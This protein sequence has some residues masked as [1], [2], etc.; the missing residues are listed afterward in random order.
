MKRLGGRDLRRWAAVLLAIGL[1][2][3][4][5]RLAENFALSADE[6]S[7]AVHLLDRDFEGLT[8]PL[9]YGQVAPVGFL[10]T[11]LAVSRTLGLSEAALRLPAWIA[12]LAAFGLFWS[13]AWRLLDRRRAALAVGFFAA[14]YYVV[15]YGAEVKPYAGDVLLSLG[16]VWLAWRIL[17]DGQAVGPKIGLTLLAAAGVW[18]SYP[19]VFVA[20]GAGAVLAWR[21]LRAPS[22]RA[23]LFVVVYGLALT[24]SFLSVFVLIYRPQARDLP[25]WFAGYWGDAF[26]PVAQPLRL[27]W[28][29]ID[30][31]AGVMLAYPAGAAHFGSVLTLVCVVAGVVWMARARRD[32]L[33]LLLSPLPFAFAAAALHLYPY[34]DAIR[35]SLY[36][37]PAFCLLA[38]AG[39]VTI[40]GAALPAR[41][42]AYGLHAAVAGL[43][44][45]AAGGMAVDVLRPYKE[46]GDHENR[47]VLRLLCSR[48]E[49]GDE[50]VVL[51]GAS[52]ARFRFY[53][54]RFS[55]V[56]VR[57]EGAGLAPREP[58]RAS[59]IAYTYQGTT[60]PKEPLRTSLSVLAQRQGP[61][62][63]LGFPLED[64]VIHVY[65]FGGRFLNAE[66]TRIRASADGISP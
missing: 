63:H 65:E 30:I 38:G 40:L 10:W 61:W 44:A 3:R 12:S 23:L 66:G 17:E 21:A 42:A 19:A 41:R 26:P 52:E 13:L 22:R 32:L 60:L 36:M 29:L 53:L 64:G 2:W 14:S 59:L 35:T 34:G 48:S 47:D 1:A 7:V 27:L 45:F 57:W 55:P 50:W 8:K 49:P 16:I 24:A 58:S 62:R 37:A 20:A 46:L 9:G 5:V 18:F 56:R 15:R 39:L 6:A 25:E 51:N 28:W 31:H 33:L 4:V 43:A 54:S 11:E